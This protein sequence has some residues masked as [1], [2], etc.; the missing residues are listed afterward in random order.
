M[1]PW[2]TE[3]FQDSEK[4]LIHVSLH[5]L[6]YIEALSHRATF[7]YNWTNIHISPFVIKKTFLFKNNN[8]SIENACVAFVNGANERNEF[9]R[10]HK[11]T[12]IY[13]EQ[14]Q[15]NNIAVIDIFN[16]IRKCCKSG[17][18]YF[19]TLFLIIYLRSIETLLCHR[20]MSLTGS[21]SFC[22]AQN[23]I[24]DFHCFWQM[25]QKLELS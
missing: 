16:E 19:H 6:K 2:P 8:Q 9:F 1:V 13:D 17:S 20:E 7:I 23:M 22:F 11:Q 12:E 14:V 5:T 21:A 24:H 15:E 25:P 3:K 18:V 4:V 10:K